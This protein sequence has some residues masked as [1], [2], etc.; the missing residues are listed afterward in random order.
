LHDTG[1]LV[2]NVSARSNGSL[3]VPL[4]VK[5]MPVIHGLERLVDTTMCGIDVVAGPSALLNYTNP[6]R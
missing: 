4:A 1:A 5:L 3:Y 2:K 6:N